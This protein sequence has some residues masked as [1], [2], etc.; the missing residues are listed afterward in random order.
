[1]EESVI[2]EI[3]K[4]LDGEMGE[5]PL[6]K[7]DQIGRTQAFAA[8]RDVYKSQIINSDFSSLLNTIAVGYL[9]PGIPETISYV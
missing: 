8:G 5:L 9:I 1:M 2:L 4:Y 7:R 6:A 3:E